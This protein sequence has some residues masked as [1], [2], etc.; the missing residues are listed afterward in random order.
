MKKILLTIILIAAIATTAMIAYQAGKDH[1]IYT[2]EL[3]ICEMP[4]MGDDYF[5][6]F[7]TVDGE[8]HIYDG[9]IC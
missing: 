8:T 4:E 3:Y 6:V 1:A 7:A 5:E 9:C 2:Q